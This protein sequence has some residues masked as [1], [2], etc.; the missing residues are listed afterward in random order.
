MLIRTKVILTRLHLWSCATLLIGLASGCSAGRPGLVANCGP[1]DNTVSC[2]V[3]KHVGNPQACGL[4]STDA[5]L[6]LGMLKATEA[7]EEEEEGD[8]NEGWRDQCI[9]L[10]VACKQ[11]AWEGNCHDCLRWCQGQ[12]Q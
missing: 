1:T 10:Y 4:N 12:K 11:R 6:I 9:N 3:K 8:P 5:T 7:A 2:C